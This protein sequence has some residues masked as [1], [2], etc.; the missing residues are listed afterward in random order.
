MINTN[1]LLAVALASGFVCVTIAW[2]PELLG[3]WSG[4][5]LAI[6]WATVTVSA[7][8]LLVITLLVAAGVFVFIIV[9]KFCLEEF[10]NGHTRTSTTPKSG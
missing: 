6:A 5:V 1:V 8:L 7:T 4:P 9:T 3:W 2:R 10:L